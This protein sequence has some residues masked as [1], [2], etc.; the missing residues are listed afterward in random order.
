MAFKIN[1]NQASK[2]DIVENIIGINDTTADSIVR[3]R[4]KTGGFT[5]FDELHNIGDVD[6][7]T[8]KKIRN[9]STL[10]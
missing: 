6:R 8:E 5:N 4:E 9:A 1:L 3:Y 2:K 7:E 10:E